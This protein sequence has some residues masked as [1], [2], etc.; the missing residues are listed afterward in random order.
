MRNQMGSPVRG[1][2]CFGREKF[3]EK[4]WQRIESGH[5]LLAA[6]R[7]FGKTSVI[8]R[9]IDEPRDG[10]LVIHADLEYYEEPAQLLTELIAELSRARGFSVNLAGLGKGFQDIVQAMRKGVADT[11]SEIEYADFKVAVRQQ[12]RADWQKTGDALFAQLAA[13]KRPILFVLDEFP[14]MID[15]MARSTEHRAEAITLLR[16]L[17]S[18]R[19]APEMSDIHFL[20]AGSI[21]IDSVIGELGEIK[22]INDFERLRLEPFAIPKAKTFLKVL[23]EAHEVPL[24]PASRNLMLELVGEPVP[25]FLQILFSQILAVHENGKKITPAVIRQIY[26][27]RVLGIDCKNYFEY[28]Y[29]R[30]RD[31]YKRDE[32]RAIKRLLRE[33]ARDG[34]MTR[35]YAFDIYRAEIAAPIEH[36]RFNR[37]MTD[38]ENDF[39]IGQ[40]GESYDYYFSCSLLRDWWLRYYGLS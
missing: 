22:S 4:L 5:V 40:D 15:R 12:T 36:D 39:Y 37:L 38:L 26:R 29:S 20:I 21:G 1:M 8:Y 27:D 34:R 2:D 18:L 25:Y 33:L 32:E 35:E 10:F 9:L 6:P 7:R 11:F 28:Y 3:V 13:S 16:W 23:S 17:R 31:Y 30:L 19:Q 14:M 24:S